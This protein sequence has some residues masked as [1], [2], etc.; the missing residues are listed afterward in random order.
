MHTLNNNAQSAITYALGPFAD[1][2]TEEFVS[3]V[4]SNL[5]MPSFPQAEIT[6]NSSSQFSDSGIPAEYDWRSY[7]KV[8]EVYN[9]SSCGSW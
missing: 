7:G 8:T 5:T 4:L 6:E 1:L 2:S 3:Q 9:Q